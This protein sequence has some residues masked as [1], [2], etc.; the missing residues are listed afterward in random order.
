M[1]N[2][3][4]ILRICY[5]TDRGD[6]ESAQTCHR[7]LSSSYF[8]LLFFLPIAYAD[9]NPAIA[10]GDQDKTPLPQEPDLAY[11]YSGKLYCLH[12][13]DRL[14]GRAG[15]IPDRSAKMEIWKAKL[16]LAGS[17]VKEKEPISAFLGEESMPREGVLFR[18]RISHGLFCSADEKVGED[19]WFGCIPLDEL[20]KP[21]DLRKLQV[22][23][24]V[25]WPCGDRLTPITELANRAIAGKAGKG[26]K[27]EVSSQSPWRIADAFFDFLPGDK[28]EFY[29]FVAWRGQLRVWRGVI[30][31]EAKIKKGE[32][33]IQWDNAL[34]ATAPETPPDARPVL[35]LDT[36]MR[37]AFIAY[38]SKTHFFFV[39]ASGKLYSC[40]K[41]GEQQRTELLWN[42]VN[43]P[44]RAV[45]HDTHS[46]K[47]FAFTSCPARGDKLGRNVWFEFAPKLEPISYDRKKIP[48]WKPA[49][50]LPSMM[51]YARILMKERKTKPD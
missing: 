30:K 38:Q 20:S 16:A 43:S 37:E 10:A 33:V 14:N 41:R 36:D 7:L 47:T 32:D 19:T 45:I 2:Q 24:F 42:D 39:T 9:F 29:A 15:H 13:I 44:I 18:W 28:R 49:D 8:L 12:I 27:L 46:Q 40:R 6:G 17:I 48:G 4:N 22:N 11:L 3:I 50:P 25:K 51:E 35:R 23:D 1:K 34:P 5:L 26:V 31:S 21:L